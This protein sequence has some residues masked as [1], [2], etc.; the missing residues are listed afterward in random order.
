VKIQTIQLGG[1]RFVVVEEGYFR[2]LRQRAGQRANDEPESPPFPE[3]DT[4]GRVL[5][6]EY[7]R[8]SIA[9]DIIRERKSLGLSQ[10]RLARIAGIRQ[11]TLSRIETG[12]HTPTVRI[13]S[14]IDQALSKARRSRS[15]MK[16]RTVSAKSV[17]SRRHRE[18]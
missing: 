15:S 1:K 9:R 11:E 18:G 16:G 2:R 6:I 5:A 10:E 12:K 4:K 14:K 7:A 3:P 17:R 8:A 13:V